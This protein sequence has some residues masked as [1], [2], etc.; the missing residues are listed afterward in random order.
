MLQTMPAF[1]SLCPVSAA[2]SA[3]LSNGRG[4]H[5]IGTSSSAPAASFNG[6]QFHTGR[7]SRRLTATWRGLGGEIIRF[8]GQEHFESEYCGPF[9][10]LI[11]YDGVMR[12]RGESVLDGAQPSA[13]R[14]LNQRMTFV[15]A[16]FR[17]REWLDPRAT[18]R[19]IYLY[20]A[21]SGLL[22]A[23]ELGRGPIAFAPRLFIENPALWQ[24]VLKLSSL[25]EDGPSACARYA[26]ALGAV[27]AH[28]L[29][30]LNGGLEPNGPPVR[31]GLAGW[32]RRAVGEYLEK[33]LAEHIPLSKLAELA[34]LSRY[35]FCRAFKHS[36]GMPP[37]R[38]QLS[39][40]IDQAKVLLS[41]ANTSVTDIALEVG[42][43]DTSAFTAAFRKLAG[44]TPTEYRR[45]LV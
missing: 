18:G 28:E 21:A 44:R 8:A 11:A 4:A 17:F 36:F 22:N 30:R 1:D 12:L 2:S 5:E 45:S 26:D 40:R 32:Q 33:H 7:I 31:G 16:G 42:F 13:L 20:I 29:L 37:H 24:T 35:H 9:H 27:L 15:P 6:V 43:S 14:N 34:Q 25:I 3:H 39:R 23:Q 41:E 10:L 19:A 38:F